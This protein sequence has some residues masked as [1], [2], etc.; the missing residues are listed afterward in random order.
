MK[1][2]P[3]LPQPPSPI[4]AMENNLVLVNQSCQDILCQQQPPPK[5]FKCCKSEG[6]TI[7]TRYLRKDSIHRY[8]APEKRPWLS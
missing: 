6:T 5:S 3:F 7:P 8:L 2:A 1:N 4:G